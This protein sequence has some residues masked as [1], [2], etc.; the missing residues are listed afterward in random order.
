MKDSKKIEILK[1]SGLTTLAGIISRIFSVPHS[2]IFAKFLMPSGFGL[3][4]IINVVISYFAYAQ[5]GILQAMNRN[6]PKEYANNDIR[7][8][9]KIKDQ[10]FTWL[11][12]ATF[13]ALF[14]LWFI[15]LF[16]EDF[17]SQLSFSN[18]LL[19]T[20]IVIFRQINSFIKPLLKAEGE[21]IK[22]GKVLVVKNSVS[23][24][25]GMILVYFYNI[26]GALYALVID[27]LIVLISS[28]ILYSK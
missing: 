9:Q 27:Q 8:V 16:N 25:I 10:A 24:I 1:F 22:L 14:I 26:S 17:N 15:Y 20:S 18:I 5:L 7:K 28:L 13:F 6:V 23:P 12:F 11:S 4:Q 21:F 3:L 2:I 19:I